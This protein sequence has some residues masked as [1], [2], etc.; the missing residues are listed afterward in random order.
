MHFSKEE[1]L[2]NFMNLIRQKALVLERN[3]V[4]LLQKLGLFQSRQ[5]ILC[6]L[7]ASRSIP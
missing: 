1:I 2:T 3:R 7:K 5:Y 4:S 6:V